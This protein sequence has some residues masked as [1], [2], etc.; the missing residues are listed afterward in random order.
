MMSR[1]AC[2]VRFNGVHSGSDHCELGAC[3]ITRAHRM[4]RP[5]DPFAAS[6]SMSPPASRRCERVRNGDDEDD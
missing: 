4:R 2:E 6:V 3:A 5:S 1:Q